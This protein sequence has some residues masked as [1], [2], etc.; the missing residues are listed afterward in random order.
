MSASV[1]KLS[2]ICPAYEEEAVLPRFH[3]ELTAV[4]DSLPPEYDAE[5]IYVD[6]GSSDGTLTVLRRLAATDR[7]VHYLS[8]SRNFGHQAAITAGLEHATGDAVITLDSDLQ[9]PPS[10]I[11][12]LLDKW[13]EGNDIVMT[14]REEDPDLGPIKRVT[15]RAFFEVM[16][17]LSETEMRIAA[18]DYRLMSRRAVD[19]LLRFP[20]THRFLRGMVHWLGFPTATVRFQVASRGA[21]QSKFTFRRLFAFAIDALLSFSKVPLRLSFVLG[22]TILLLGAVYCVFECVRGLLGHGFGWELVLAAVLVVG[23]C[24]LASLGLLG[25]YVGRI[26]EQVKGRPLYLLK[27]QWPERAAQSGTLDSRQERPPGN[28]AA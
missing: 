25:E 23:G 4:L 12:T 17:W 14:L 13:R 15:S 27:E 11:P 8:L 2:V 28:A 19:A 1:R 7:R 16:R 24:I 22:M 10:L 6:D 21:G 26:Y 3:A 18:S 9:H 20:E 5:V